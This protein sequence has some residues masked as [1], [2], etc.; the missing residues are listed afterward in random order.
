M[1]I[2]VHHTASGVTWTAERETSYI[3][4]EAPDNP[5]GNGLLTRTK[6]GPRF[7]LTS[8]RATNTQGRGGPVL[9]SRGVI[10]LDS[11]NTRLF[12]IEAANNGIGETWPPD[13]YDLYLRVCIA[14]LECANA[15]QDGAD[16]GVGDI[17]AHFEWTNPLDPYGITRKSDPWGPSPANTNLNIK[18]NMTTFRG[19]VLQRWLQ[20][21]PGYTPPVPP[22]P[23]IPL[24]GASDMIYFVAKASSTEGGSMRMTIDF[25]TQ[26]RFGH[27]D[28]INQF[29]ARMNQ[30]RSAGIP[31]HVIN[32]ADGKVVDDYS[33]VT[34]INDIWKLGARVSS[35]PANDPTP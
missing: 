29:I 25:D 16:L 23:E 9:S 28:Q 32:Y 33:D 10:P 15:T 13:M 34:L 7:I 3:A 5:I 14:V 19:H 22:V 20:G 27:I 17:W 21:P 24:E 26:V 4:D 6:D 12:S 18:W 2:G 11:G 31:A 8:V 1:G 30:L 35:M